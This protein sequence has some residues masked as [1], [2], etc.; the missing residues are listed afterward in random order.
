MLR[1]VFGGLRGLT[2]LLVL[3]ATTLAVAQ[4]YQSDDKGYQK[5]VDKA[6]GLIENGRFD[7]AISP[8][9]KAQ[10]KADTTE[11][12][13]L[14][15]RALAG[16]GSFDQAVKVLSD[17]YS[18]VESDQQSAYEAALKEVGAGA[19]PVSVSINTNAT[20]ATVK[21][22]GTEVGTAPG[23]FNIKVGRHKIR[24]SKTGFSDA[25]KSVVVL[26][27][28][29]RKVDLELVE[30]FG[31]V[32]LSSDSEGVSAIVGGK[33]YE[34]EAGQPTDVKVA[35]G[36]AKVEFQQ[37]EE[38]VQTENITVKA[39]KTAEV[40]YY[41]FGNLVIDG[42]QG[43]AMVNIAGKSYDVTP[44][45]E[46]LS[47]PT[48]EHTMNVTG[49]GMQPVRG[50]IKIVAK[51]T[52][53]VTVPYTEATDYT[54]PKALGWTAL[55]TGLALIV[56]TIVI[57]ETVTFDDTATHDGVIFGL[58]GAGAALTIT[59][60]IVLKEYLAK[61]SNPEVMDVDYGVTVGAAPTRD[62]GVITAGFTF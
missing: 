35:T 51:K 43:P 16:T 2:V 42:I 59:G 50:Q 58:A 54:V 40:G 14:K 32:R 1:V 62:G 19:S 47:V 12:R 15:A 3:C 55:G 53:K 38:T 18:S 17:A 10:G 56:T 13:I 34:L 26:P 20:G 61:E 4:S 33:T 31:T 28:R 9:E 6:R 8:I 21:V 57:E 44:G 41:G 48:G 24:A 23:P 22:D 30:Q 25:E 46:P 36:A 5:A 49:D 37:A 27:G 39:G 11:V 45:H 52:T 29:T 60:G 7:Q